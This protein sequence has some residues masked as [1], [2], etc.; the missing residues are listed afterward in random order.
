MIEGEILFTLINNINIHYEVKGEGK[1]IVLLHGWGANSYTFEGLVKHL[2]Q[3]FRVITVDLPGFGES[4]IKEALSVEQV[5]E[6]IRRLLIFLNIEKPIILGHSYGGRIGIKYCSKYQAERLILVASAGIKQNL[7][8]SKK[9][10]IMVYKTL[11]KMHISL[12]MGSSD[13]KNASPILKKMLVMTI[14]EDLSE[15]LKQIK[16]PTLLIWGKDD[17]VTKLLDAKKMEELID[18]SG[19]V[20]MENCGHFPYLEQPVYFKIVLDSFLSASND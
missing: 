12:N 9:I 11:K 5:S 8:I 20:V 2:E 7:S 14:N 1:P 19:M 3:S 6:V 18:D 10:R 16:I 15:D 17:N 13:Y 4:E